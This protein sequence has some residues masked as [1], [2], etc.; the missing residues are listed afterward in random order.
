MPGS[1]YQTPGKWQTAV[2]FI[3]NE[4]GIGILSLPAAM[5]TLGLIPGIIAIIGLGLVTT[6]TAYVLVQFYRRYPTVMNI[7]DCCQIIG[8][9]P[10]ARITAIAFTLNLALTCASACLTM[11][12]ALNSMSDHALCTIAF[13]ALPAIT[14]WAL[15]LPRKF[16]FI[17]HC[18]IPCTVSIIA[19]VLIVMISL[20]IAERPQG[21]LP[22]WER[23]IVL[24]GTPTF[25]QGMSA[26]LNI[27][28]AY[29]GNQ[30]FV[31]VMA[32]MKNAARDFTPA[33]IILQSFAIPIYT[34]VAAVIYA[35]A[36]QGVR[37][38]ALGSAP[39]L[40]AKIAYGIL[41][42]CL[43]GTSL[44]FAH[45]A[46]KYLFVVGLRFLRADSEYAK[47][48]TR[49]WTLWISIGTAFWFLSFIIANAV[50]VFDSILSISSAIFVAWFTFG[51]SGVFWLFL[52]W[53]QQG[54]GWRRICLAGVNWG[55]VVVTVFVNGAGMYAAVSGLLARFE[56]ESQG[57]NGPFTCADN[58][59]F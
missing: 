15:C 56:D 59:I 50:P 53:D 14:S 11:S 41:F 45:T 58:S 19:A 12:I 17:A 39:T 38:P 2:I 54:K 1:S 35:L 23:E 28:F 27:A 46:I 24:V 22:G 6:Y 57:V 42:P 30:G 33:L 21:A 25:S 29:A 52:N 51:I 40:P 3:T 7:V 18:G 32:E 34:I 5:Q 44:V 20:G 55:I 9:K 36:G 4:V 26:C 10:L 47:N 16:A 37:S 43:L 48:T 13:I 31:T 49:S 8:G